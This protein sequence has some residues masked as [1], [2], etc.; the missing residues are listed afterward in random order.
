MVYS[1]VS[2]NRFV[3]LSSTWTFPGLPDVGSTCLPLCSLLSNRLGGSPYIH[4]VSAHC[5]V[6]IVIS[7]M[8]QHSPGHACVLVGQCHRSHVRMP[9]CR[10]LG[11][12]ATE[13]VIFMFGSCHHR[14]G[15]VDHQHSQVSITALTNTK[16]AMLVAR[17]IK[18]SRGV[19]AGMH[20]GVD[21]GIDSCSASLWIGFYY[22]LGIVQKLAVKFFPKLLNFFT[23]Q[24]VFD[25]RL[26]VFVSDVSI[27]PFIDQFD[28]PIPIMQAPN[29]G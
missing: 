18:I 8:T 12:P 22:D 16:Q 2:P 9:P 17:A 20:G 14:S 19:V 6:R 7:F 29:S 24:D 15:A 25:S 13:R 3:V 4:P 5:K 11:D 10:D 26:H 28:D 1:R 21:L 27:P 23:F